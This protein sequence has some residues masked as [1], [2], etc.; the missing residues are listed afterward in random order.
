MKTKL[1]YLIIVLALFAGVQR[2][3][4]AISNVEFTACPTVGLSPLS[5]QFSTTNNYIGDAVK[6]WNWNFGDGST[7]TLQNPSHIYAVVGSFIPNLTV[8]NINGQVGRSPFEPEVI[9]LTTGIINPD[10][11]TPVV[12]SVGSYYSFQLNPTGA[13]WA[14]SGNAGIA[15]NG[16][17][18][19]Y[20]NGGTPYGNQFAFL[21]YYQ[22]GGG[23]M[24]Q[25]ISN[26]PAGNYTF[27]FTASQR[28]IVGRDNTQNQGVT[29]LVDGVN[30]GSFTPAD[31]NWYSFQTTPI[32]LNAGN[33]V[34]TFTTLVAAVDA[35][36]RLDE[37]GIVQAS[38]T[39]VIM[40]QPQ[41][42]FVT[43]GAPAAFNVVVS[44]TPPFNY[45]WQKDGFSLSDG[46]NLS[47]SATNNLTL[48][49]TTTNDTGSYT[50]IITN[51]FGSVTS[52]V[53]K[54]TLM[55]PAYYATDLGTF[56]GS[57]SYARGINNSGQVVG[58]SITAGNAEHAFLYSGG[59]MN[60]LGTLGGSYSFA[61]G[62]N[63]SGQVVGNSNVAGN[64]GN[65]FLYSSGTMTDLGTLGGSY[66]EAFG[67]N[68]NGQIAGDAG[69]AGNADHAFLYSDGTMND[70]GTLGGSSS[71]A[72]GINISG[73]VVGY[74]YLAGDAVFH[75]FLYSGGTMNDL[76]TLGGSYSRAQG[77]NNSGQVV[78]YSYTAGN[79]IA[80]AFLS[81]SGTMN[82]LGTLGGSYCQANG[83]NNSGQVVGYSITAGNANHAFLYS[84]GSML[85]LNNLVAT[86]SLGAGI[87]F[88]SAEGINDSG[89]IIASGI[90]GHA[91][92]LTP[93]QTLT[94]YFPPKF[95]AMTM[96]N[97]AFQFSWNTV[98]TYPAVGYQMQTTTNLTSPNWINLGPVLTGV[99]PTISTT[100]T[101]STDAQRFYR[102]LL[103]Q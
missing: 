29:V 51:S 80:H 87:Y 48:S 76:G 64:P 89:Q 62:V 43:N 36:V 88:Q 52:S 79:A 75:A 49:T 33:H 26:L 78:G 25:T 39:P 14:F 44:G 77:I 17:G 35:T 83:I 22:G 47:G 18:Y 82:D 19:A 74:S 42:L 73:Q 71:V 57:D 72:Q 16:S 9:I 100:D 20:Y 55:L 50:V 27:T 10:F 68:N 5:V 54:L 103:V 56:G 101:N 2:V 11:E 65:A 34:L 66:S 90:N 40:T 94:G 41:S 3:V 97:G 24:S 1:N 58:Y 38:P 4:A 99:G 85:D 93:A 30:V 69:T 28:D 53:A 96:T 92:L 31:T 86:N 67:I 98:N 21:Q 37:I 15:A 12:G 45:Q 91:Y 70:L 32:A 8:T 46:G 13:G 23:S 95:Q 60:D 61:D 59:T 102:V 7:S 63:N 84:G 81:S 6:N